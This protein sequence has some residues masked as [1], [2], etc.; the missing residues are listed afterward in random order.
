MTKILYLFFAIIMHVSQ[1]ASDLEVSKTHVALTTEE[2][3]HLL[4]C[5]ARVKKCWF[6]GPVKNAIMELPTQESSVFKAI[7]E[8]VEKTNSREEMVNSLTPIDHT[9]LLI[10]A[11]QSYGI[12]WK[13]AA[14]AGGLTVFAIGSVA[15]LGAVVRPNNSRQL[16]NEDFSYEDSLVKI[17]KDFFPPF[18][19]AV[20]IDDGYVVS[21]IEYKTNRQG[22]TRRAGRLNNE[23][24]TELSPGQLVILSQVQE[25]Y[26]HTIESI[27]VLVNST[28]PEANIS[29][30]VTSSKNISYS[31][32]ISGTVS[33]FIAA[34]THSSAQSGTDSSSTESF[35]VSLP[36]PP[37]EP[38]IL[39]PSIKSLT[40]SPL[41]KSLS[42]SA[43]PPHSP[44]KSLTVSLTPSRSSTKSNSPTKSFTISLTRSLS[45]TGTS[46]LT[47]SHSRSL[48][49][50]ATASQTIPD[51]SLY[52]ELSCKQIGG[53]KFL[54]DC[55]KYRCSPNATKYTNPMLRIF[56]LETTAPVSTADSPGCY[57][58]NYSYDPEQFC[59]AYTSAHPHG[60]RNA[61]CTCRDI[62]VPNSIGTL[63]DGYTNGVCYPQLDY[64]YDLTYFR[65]SSDQ[66]CSRGC[67]TAGMACRC[68]S[69]ADCPQPLDSCIKSPYLGNPLLC[70]KAAYA[71][72]YFTTFSAQYCQ[73]REASDLTCTCSSVAECR[74]PDDCISVTK[75]GN[76]ISVCKVSYA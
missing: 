25:T 53:T 49:L 11:I 36:G 64:G 75:N 32:N 41:T 54:L 13:T 72:W 76:N 37:T 26:Q 43:A 62:R 71:G 30:E 23:D 16:P 45:R 58:A 65:C 34:L 3:E 20:P 24:I 27:S 21:F 50:I 47:A 59:A 52:P 61:A 66:S 28:Y 57:F 4:R 15:A 70:L 6:F 5:C 46:T 39:N 12:P 33:A 29:I 73:S 19:V 31:K 14:I 63:V 35:T 10:S 42:A 44:T 40:A 2:D 51:F 38:S 55:I 67:H 17:N 1:Q 8:A 9:E 18:D 22:E 60:P 48:T 56:G 74:Y 69:D 7:F 68:V